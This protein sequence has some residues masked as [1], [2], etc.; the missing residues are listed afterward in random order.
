MTAAIPPAIAIDRLLQVDTI[1]AE[2]AAMALERGRQVLARFPDA[3]IVEVGSHW[4]TPGLHGNAGNVAEWNA[5]KRALAALRTPAR[6]GCR[7]RV[8][9]RCQDRARARGWISSE[10]PT[11]RGTPCPRPHA[12]SPPT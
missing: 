8:L 12:A 7:L 9:P 4:Q 6:S 10:H 11:R 5:I 2:P 3:D 1:Y